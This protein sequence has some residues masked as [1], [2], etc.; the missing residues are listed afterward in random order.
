MAS[1]RVIPTIS[2]ETIFLSLRH[3]TSNEPKRGFKP[4]WNDQAKVTPVATGARG[5][6]VDVHAETVVGVT[7][8]ARWLTISSTSRTS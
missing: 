1:D 7:E 8:T 4:A 2:P 5:V 6:D 3:L